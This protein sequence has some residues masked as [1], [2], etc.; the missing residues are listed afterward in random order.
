M[1]F[2]T[3]MPADGMYAEETIYNMM[4]TTGGTLCYVYE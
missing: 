1:Q 3:T 4:D 2:N